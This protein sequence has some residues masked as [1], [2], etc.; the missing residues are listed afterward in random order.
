MAG[1]GGDMAGAA[2]SSV[3]TRS[4]ATL[5]KVSRLRILAFDRFRAMGQRAQRLNLT[6]GERAGMAEGETF[7]RQGAHLDARQIAHLV[8]QARQHPADLAV[9]AFADRD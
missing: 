6:T 4:T 8:A 2:S 1:T 7:E 3:A 9:A 5:S